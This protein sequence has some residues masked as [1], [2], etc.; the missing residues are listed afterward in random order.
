MRIYVGNLSHNTTAEQLTAEFAAYG[1]VTSSEVVKDRYS[2]ESKGFAFVEMPA[3]AE[4][5]AALSA[6]NSKELDGRGITVSEARP[7]GE[8]RRERR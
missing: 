8:G 5:R 3:D 2:G 7:R 6:L 4:A 1:Q